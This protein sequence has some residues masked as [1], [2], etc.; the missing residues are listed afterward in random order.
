M[1]VSHGRFLSIS[2]PFAVI[3]FLMKKAAKARACRHRFWRS[4]ALAVAAVAARAR[5]TV[6]TDIA[7]A[8]VADIG[9]AAV[10]RI[11]AHGASDPAHSFYP[12]F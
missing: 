12:P 10:Y 7:P 3:L 2:I 8:F 1:F 11:V 6:G 5:H 9:G 4:V